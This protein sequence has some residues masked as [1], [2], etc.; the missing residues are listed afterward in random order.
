MS[1]PLRVAVWTA[2]WSAAPL[3]QAV[4]QFL[5]E[6]F[7]PGHLS[8]ECA[9]FEVRWVEVAV[10]Q[11]TLPVSEANDLQASDLPLHLRLDAQFG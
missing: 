9:P 7:L 11:F 8:R 10:M 6:S 4:Q 2:H 1:S 5:G 3:F